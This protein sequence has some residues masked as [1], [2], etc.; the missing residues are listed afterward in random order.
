MKATKIPIE[1]EIQKVKKRLGEIHNEKIQWERRTAEKKEQKKNL[2]RLDKEHNTLTMK[3][4]LLEWELNDI[5][6]YHP[7]DSVYAIRVESY[8]TKK[9]KSVPIYRYFGVVEDNK[10]RRCEKE[11]THEFVHSNFEQEFVAILHKHHKEKSW[12]SLQ[13]RSKIETPDNIQSMLDELKPVYEYQIQADSQKIIFVKADAKFVKETPKQING[14]KNVEKKKMTTFSELRWYVLTENEFGDDETTLHSYKILD[15]GLLRSCC[16]EKQVTDWRTDMI[17]DFEAERKTKT[18]VAR[19]IDTGDDKSDR[20]LCQYGILDYNQQFY[21]NV[22]D[23][24]YYVN[25]TKQQINNIRYNSEKQ[26]FLG[27]S[28]DGK[29]IVLEEAWV[30]DNFKKPFLD[31]LKSISNKNNRSYICVPE[32]NAMDLHVDEDITKN[33]EVRYMQEGENSCAF[34]SLSSI[35]FYLGLTFEADQLNHHRGLF[36]G[37]DLEIKNC[38]RV[39]SW[40]LDIF[41]QDKLFNIFNSTYV[42]KKLK[43]SQDVLLDALKPGEFYWIRLKAK[44]NSSNHVIG[45][46]DRWIFDGNCSNALSLCRKNLDAC[47]A[48]KYDGFKKGYHFQFREQ[49]SLR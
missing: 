10:G 28:P 31:N 41:N 42:V 13:N 47:C 15:E 6:L 30:N 23:E 17:L 7:L 46:I 49:T 44:D 19:T 20:D 24:Q 27:L 34:S 40:I 37:T 1:K 3:K 5:E 9:P 14:K 43:Q 4:K 11:L 29:S 21:F 36:F 38:H 48:D 12:F 39:M 2:C 8:T 26:C 22:K 16:T 33:P 18:R 25:F 45:I 32:G 35:L